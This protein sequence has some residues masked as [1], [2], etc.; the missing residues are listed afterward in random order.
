MSRNQ[1]KSRE[2]AEI[3]EIKRTHWNEGKPREVTEMKGNQEKSEIKG[4][5]EKSVKS[6]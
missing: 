5:K 1:E 2:L 4:N 3:T 6:R